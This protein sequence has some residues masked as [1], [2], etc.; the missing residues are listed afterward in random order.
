[1]AMS[2]PKIGQISSQPLQIP[3]HKRIFDRSP[4]VC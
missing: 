2:W 3:N 1:L 4:R